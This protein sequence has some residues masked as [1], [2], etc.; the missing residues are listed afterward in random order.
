NSIV[1]DIGAGSGAVG[2]EA[3]RLCSNGWV[4]AVEKNE[5]DFEIA[6]S[7][8]QKM[9]VHHY[10]LINNKAPQGMDQW[11]NP[12]AVF[13]GGSGGEL[14]EL[15]R[16]ILSR[17]NDGGSL[18]MNFVTIENLSAAV[19]TL[20]AMDVDWDVTQM[21]VSRS[22]PILHMHRMAAENPVWIV[23]VTRGGK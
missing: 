7:N 3:A 11:P 12:D 13:I 20:K 19:E 2:L 14:A 18:V 4:Y 16:L 8:Q 23:S 15:I 22:K 1:W 6:K 10:T 21:Q 9:S 5:A 17:L